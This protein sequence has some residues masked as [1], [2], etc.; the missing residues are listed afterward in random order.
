MNHRPYLHG[1]LTVSARALADTDPE[2]AATIQG[3]AH[4]L[5]AIPVPRDHDGNDRRATGA[6]TGGPADRG[7]LIVDTRRETTRLLVEALGDERL[8]ALRDHGAAMDTD[9]AVAYT[10]ARLETFLTMTGAS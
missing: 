8:R 2:G 7:G 10:L 4:A 5:L 1:T 6:R 3:A 9:T